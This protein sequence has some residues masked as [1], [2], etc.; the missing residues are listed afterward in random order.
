MN[1]ST[2]AVSLNSHNAA[3]PDTV[4]SRL[5][6]GVVLCISAISSEVIDRVRHAIQV[7]FEQRENPQKREPSRQTFSRIRTDHLPTPRNYR[8][9]TSQD[10]HPCVSSLAVRCIDTTRDFLCACTVTAVGYVRQRC[11]T[12]ICATVVALSYPNTD[13]HTSPPLPST[14]YPLP[15]QS[16]PTCNVTQICL[17]SADADYAPLPPALTKAVAKYT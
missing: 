3:K 7:L 6:F 4:H 16:H 9:L 15:F 14:L 2:S 5:L 12:Y 1:Q 11:N 17:C 10:D 13:V 8:Q